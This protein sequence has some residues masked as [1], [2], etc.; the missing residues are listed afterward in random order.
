MCLL[1]WGAASLFADQIRA[2]DHWIALIL[3]VII[4]GKMIREGFE[5]DHEDDDETPRKT[6][7]V[8]TIVTAIG[9]SIDSAAVGVALAVASV[10]AWAAL[11]IGTFSFVAS[12]VGFLIGPMV[13]ERLGKR[14]EIGGGVILVLIGISIFVSHVYG[15]G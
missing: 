15:G 5:S 2:V 8:G 7:W 4:G 1:G 9:T 14:A 12:T 11:M 3:L 10:T 6:G 13:G